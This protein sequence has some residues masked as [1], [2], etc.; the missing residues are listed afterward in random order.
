MVGM[1]RTAH[2]LTERRTWIYEQLAVPPNPTLPDKSR[3][4]V[5]LQATNQLDTLSVL[6][7]GVVDLS[8]LEVQGKFSG[9]LFPA[10]TDRGVAMKQML[11]SD[12]QSYSVEVARMF[13]SKNGYYGRLGIEVFQFVPLARQWVKLG[14][15]A[16]LFG[17]GVDP[18][19]FRMSA[20][21]FLSIPTGND[22]LSIRGESARRFEWGASLFR[23]GGFLSWT[24]RMRDNTNPALYES[25][26]L[27][28]G[29]YSQMNFGS[30]ELKLA[31]S[32]RLFIDKNV[33][34]DQHVNYPSEFGAPDL[35]LTVSQAF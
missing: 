20:S 24:T 13:P 10:L 9:R 27:S 17:A 14:S 4:Q 22:F 32:M 34:A 29:P 28:F 6:A 2:A 21:Y 31:V 16:G 3:T 30:G 7:A 18:W 11:Q 26:L 15:D 33:R 19:S 25:M 5:W 12:R 8:F 1:T 23:V 35:S